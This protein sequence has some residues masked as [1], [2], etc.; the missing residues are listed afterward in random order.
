[1]ATVKVRCTAAHG[2]VSAPPSKSA[3]HRALIAAALSGRSR[4]S[5]IAPSEDMAATLRWAP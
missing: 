5:G 1:M 3:A 2:V 4:I